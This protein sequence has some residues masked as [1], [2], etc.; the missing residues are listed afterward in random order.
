MEFDEV[1]NL[2]SIKKRDSQIRSISP[3]RVKGTADISSNKVSFHLHITGSLVLPSSRTLEDVHYPFD[4]HSL[5]TFLYSTSLSD[6]E[7]DDEGEVHII[8]GEMIDLKP[9]IEDLILL[10]IPIQVFKDEKEEIPSHLLS[11]KDWEYIQDEEHFQKEK[12]DPRLAGLAKLLK[13]D[14]E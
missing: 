5:E 9:V 8:Q 1:V 2:D 3:I 13:Q 6:T 4:I 11:G 7:T 12:I 10:E 14:E